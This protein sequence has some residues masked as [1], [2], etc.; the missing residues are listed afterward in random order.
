M[1][2]WPLFSLGANITHSIAKMHEREEA[3]RGRS[4]YVG[5]SVSCRVSLRHGVCFDND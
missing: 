1:G 3:I 4:V 2:L 5:V